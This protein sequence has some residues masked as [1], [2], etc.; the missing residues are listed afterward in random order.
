M[1]TSCSRCVA[2]VLGD[3]VL[4]VKQIR[5]HDVSLNQLTLKSV[6][7]RAL[8]NAAKRGKQWVAARFAMIGKLLG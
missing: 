5:H 1:N 2:N 7:V 3:S 8:A 6:H 4:N